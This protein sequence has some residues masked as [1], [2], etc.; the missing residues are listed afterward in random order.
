MT[1]YRLES[2][3]AGNGALN[4]LPVGSQSGEKLPALL[5]E[6]RQLERK[7]KKTTYLF[8]D[9]SY[10]LKRGFSSEKQSALSV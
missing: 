4:K 1:D 10:P 5:K 9:S 7:I 8:H 6:F 3:S 2:L